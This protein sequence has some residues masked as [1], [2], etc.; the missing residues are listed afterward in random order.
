MNKLTKS[1]LLT[2]LSITMLCTKVYAEETKKI[3]ANIVNDIIEVSQEEIKENKT[4]KV[5]VDVLNVRTGASTDSKILGKIY[6][7]N[8]VNII[9]ELDDWYQIEYNSNT[10]FVFGEYIDINIKESDGIG[11]V[12][13]GTEIVKYA[14]KYIGTPY[15]YGG[16]GP[17]GFDCSGFTQYIMENFGYELP[18]SSSSQ[19]AYGT[20]VTKEELILGDLVFFTSSPSSEYI[21]HVGIYVGDGNF[22]HSPIPGQS[23]KIET[24]TSGYFNNCYYGGIRVAQ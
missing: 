20:R 7:G 12:S 17:S 1:L 14:N 24:L 19:Y 21:S 15:V 5:N 23:V 11:N 8:T 18:H 3:E 16:V 22:I 13:I 4:G 9:D 10:A 6:L 2:G